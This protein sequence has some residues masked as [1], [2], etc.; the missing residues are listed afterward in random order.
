VYGAEVDDARDVALRRQLYLDAK[1]SH[2]G[3]DTDGLACP[4][5]LPMSCSHHTRE[6]GFMSDEGTL[7]RWSVDHMGTRAAE[8]YR[9]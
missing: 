4:L 7:L 6:H 5:H 9:E 8:S 3:V 1:S 2:V